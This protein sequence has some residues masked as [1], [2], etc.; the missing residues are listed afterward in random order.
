MLILCAQQSLVQIAA[1]DR[2]ERLVTNA[3]ERTVDYKLLKTTLV[4]TRQ[5]FSP[6]QSGKTARFSKAINAKSAITLCPP[7]RARLLG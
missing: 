7:Q 4:M 3:A 5:S 2:S 6:A 1:N